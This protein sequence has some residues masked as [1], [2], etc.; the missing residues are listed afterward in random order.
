[1][2]SGE[3]KREEKSARTV[4]GSRN[5]HVA[6]S[7][8]GFRA[9]AW[10]PPQA[11]TCTLCAACRGSAVAGM[12]CWPR[13]AHG[14]SAVECPLWNARCAMPGTRVHTISTSACNTLQNKASLPA[15]PSHMTCPQSCACSP[16]IR[17]R[18]PQS[19]IVQTWPRHAA[20]TW[21]GAPPLQPGG[22]P[23]A[24]KVRAYRTSRDGMAEAARAG[25]SC[26]SLQGHSKH[27]L[28]LSQRS[29]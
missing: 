19:A 27:E 22:A 20:N 26:A 24:H 14:M 16:R 4:P 28:L 23:A 25:A 18:A 12:H 21:L 1:M 7:A 3:K 9:G 29:A 13:R 8:P 6:G 11:R 5:I 10:G 2:S 15:P 17:C